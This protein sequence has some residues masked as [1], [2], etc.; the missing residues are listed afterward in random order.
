MRRVSA[1]PIVV[2]ATTMAALAGNEPP[3]DESDASFEIEPPLLIQSQPAEQRSATASSDTDPIRLEKELD[4]AKTNAISA[5]RLCKIGALSKLEVEQR[6]SKVIRLECDLEN[7]RLAQ[8]K[9]E[10]AAQR[11]RFDA[12]EISKTDVEN[13]ELALTRAT[14]SA[15]AAAAKRKQAE[16]ESAERNLHRQQKLL[17]L[18]S[19]RKSDVSRAE[20]RLAELKAQK[21]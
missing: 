17:A 16:L 8:A 15:E 12:R 20:R 14:A 13:A 2:V 5:E 3:Q 1:L 6:A 4:R 7:A 21:N 19:S 18:G 11:A 10:L 9:E